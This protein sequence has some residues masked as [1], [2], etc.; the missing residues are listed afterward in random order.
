VPV[1]L[2]MMFLST[3]MLRLASCLV[4]ATYDSP[5][6]EE[7]RSV[8]DDADDT[9]DKVGA[10]GNGTSVDSAAIGPVLE[11]A[12]ST[13]D[14]QSTEP[15]VQDF[16]RAHDADEEEYTSEDEDDE[17]E[18]SDEEEE[19]VLK[20]HKIQNAASSILE[21]DSASAIAVGGTYFVSPSSFCMVPENL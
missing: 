20:Y 18:E 9:V 11:S 1:F 16:A 12:T 6:T 4:V 14:N 19:P 2:P 8:A 13:T 3:N 10:R 21:K 7:S 17:D 15:K 5:E